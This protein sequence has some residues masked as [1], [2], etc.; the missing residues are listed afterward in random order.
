MSKH[1]EGEWRVGLS[2]EYKVAEDG[3]SACPFDCIEIETVSG[4]SLG[5][6][7]M[8]QVGEE[9]AMANSRVMVAG[10]KMLS[11]L[12]FVL[13]NHHEGRGEFE[14]IVIAAIEAATGEKP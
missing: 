4:I 6:V 9:E 7:A 13:A 8:D 5:M 2:R 12:Q 14:D 11:A 10:P 1:T 3:D